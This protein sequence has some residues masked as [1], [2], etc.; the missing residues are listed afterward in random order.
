[1]QMVETVSERTVKSV[2]PF[3][4]LS[5]NRKEPFTQE[6]ER[7]AI[8]CLAELER[9]KGGGIVLKQP[10]EKLAFIAEVC[11]PFWLVTLGEISLLFDG[12][13]TISYVLTY[14]TTPNIQAF[15]DDIKR[16]SRTRQAYM[17]SLLNN[18]N[19]FQVSGNEEKKTIAGLVAN[20]EFVNEFISYLSEAKP[21]KNEL[22]NM[23][24][25]TPTLDESLI[26]SVK[27][28]LQNL[29]SR[30]AEEVKTLY[31]SMKLVNSTTKS[32]MKAIRDE[33][34]KVEEKL[35]KQIEKCEASVEKQVDE[36]R[37]EYDEEVTV[38]S[39][40]AEEE[41]LSLQQERIKF[42]KTKERLTKEVEHCEAE[43]KTSAI[44][45]DTVTERK[46]REKRNELKTRL[47][48]AEIELKELDRR[49]KE[50]KDEKNLK[51]FETKSE[52]DEK[53]KEVMKDLLEIESSREANTRIYEEEM[54]KF[55]ELTSTIIEQIDKSAKLREKSINDFEKLGVHQKRKKYALIYLPFY[56]ACYQSESGKR[57]LTFP[58]SIAGS[59]SLSV[60]FRGALGKAKIKR[61]LQPRSKAISMLLNKFPLTMEQDIVFNREISEA[62]EKANILVKD[63]SQSIKIGLE[64]LKEDGWFSEKEYESLSQMLT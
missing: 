33:I 32:F 47:S 61:L 39:K 45:K 50:V 29:K 62:C 40:K 21:V 55:E 11:Y 3:S 27:E 37:K 60:K 59:V 63:S 14:S 51:I 30:F 12:L 24:K 18:L 57:Y 8:F 43:I 10:P 4:T 22:S 28:E 23:V 35:S 53:A 52:C 44:G 36:I 13:N 5:E 17:T 25:I 20:P 7:A 49:I 58:P 54:E 46:W 42:E 34:K 41:L 9:A 2:L 48:E 16:S 56:L 38:Y 1:M 6:I 26:T 31:T 19:Y 15:V 64:R